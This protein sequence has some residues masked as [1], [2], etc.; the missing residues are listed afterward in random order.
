MLRKWMI[1][2]AA[3]ISVTALTVGIAGADDEDSPLHK[4]M[5]QVN[6]KNLA[7]TKGVRTPVAFKKSQQDVVASAEELAKLSKEAKAYGKD[8]LKKAKDVPH[9]DVKW[10]ELMDSFTSSS[11]KLAKVAAKSDATQTQAKDAHVAVKKACTECHN[12]F[13]IEEEGF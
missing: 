9:A 7:I 13:R 10:N 4:I 2:A 8:Y 3:I 6:A 11:E 5:E 12:V 1:L